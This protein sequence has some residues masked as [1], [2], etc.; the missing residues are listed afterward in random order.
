MELEV[1]NII[2]G[3]VRDLILGQQPEKWIAI[4]TEIYEN[5]DRL[6]PTICEDGD[7]GKIAFGSADRRMKI[8]TARFLTRKLH[9]NSGFL[10]DVQIRAIQIHIDEIL[11]GDIVQT[12]I[13]T[14]LDIGNNY[15]DCIGGDSCMTGPSGYV[16]LYVDNPD[17]YSQLIM[18]RGN[19]S[20]RAM[21]VKLDNG[22]YMLDR[23]YTNAEDLTEKMKNYADYQGWIIGYDEEMPEDKTQFIVTGLS[24]TDGEVPYQDTLEF[25]RV[26]NGLLDLMADSCHDYEFTTDGTNGYVNGAAYNCCGCGEGISEEDYW[27]FDD[28]IYC[29]CC[30]MQVAFT[31]NYCGESHA[32]DDSKHISDTD[33]YVCKFCSDHHFAYCEDCGE[34]FSTGEVQ[35]IESAEKNICNDCLDQ[36]Y[37]ECIDCNEFFEKNDMVELENDDEVCKECREIEL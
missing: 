28:G 20:A 4:S 13:S 35:Y 5:L 10:N 19:D 2:F 34:Y 21:I 25:G 7:T 26:R 24:Y 3:T 16:G 37:R 9:L 12:Y 1:K 23:I 8:R 18:K 17:T 31:C 36:Y 11:F 15:Q 27:S 29:E 30:F 33:Q 14:G 6:N 32:R 22:K